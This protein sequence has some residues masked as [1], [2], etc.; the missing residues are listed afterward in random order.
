[1]H[2]Q[3]YGF[4]APGAVSDAVSI[5]VV[6]A[7]VVAASPSDAGAPTELDLRTAALPRGIVVYSGVKAFHHEARPENHPSDRGGCPLPSY[8]GEDTRYPTTPGRLNSSFSTLPSV[9]IC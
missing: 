4:A 7:L 3:G 9:R 1:M 2:A 5:V 8:A 6:A